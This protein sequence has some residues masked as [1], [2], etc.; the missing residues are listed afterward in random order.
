MLAEGGSG[1][2][3]GRALAVE[4][5][6]HA[7]Q[8]QS[9]PGQALENFQRHGLFVIQHLGGGAHRSAR[10]PRRFELRLPVRP[11][12]R[13]EHGLEQPVQRVQVEGALLVGVEAFVP[14]PLG[15]VERG[16]ETGEEPIVGRGDH[17]VAVRALVGLVGSEPANAASL[18]A[19]TATRRLRH[20][21]ENG[22]PPNGRLVKGSVHHAALPGARPAIQGGEDADRA[23][24][25]GAHVDDRSAHPH[26][27]TALLAGDAHDPPAGLHQGVVAG[28]LA[29]RPPVA[30]GPEVAIDQ[31]SV[32][33][34]QL[35]RSEAV[36]LDGSGAQ[37]LY[38]DVDVGHAE[39][40]KPRALR[41][42]LEIDGDPALVTIEGLEERG[43]A[44]G[45]QLS[46][47]ARVVTGARTL[48]LEHVRAE[49]GEEPRRVGRG[50]AAAEL[51]HPDSRE[52]FVGRQL[53]HRCGSFLGPANGRSHAN[54][55]SG[56]TFTNLLES[57]LSRVEL[58]AGDGLREVSSR[59]REIRVRILSPASR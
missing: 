20:A 29:Q 40:A 52:G 17:E 16:R 22:H 9:V 39:P 4:A 10:H 13:R 2:A 41:F 23:P 56:F 26:R 42:V 36:A 51:H 44:V 46:P 32:L 58:V 53:I 54:C 11:R 38:H 24:H 1:A 49:G 27:G 31:T 19:G 59:R 21:R 7:H 30:E 18:P 47:L 3:K 12:S 14:G 5:K 28:V 43:A 34:R 50:H 45:K 35:R 37:V 33:L 57:T 48:H 25:S 15:M 8:T 55:A 6:R